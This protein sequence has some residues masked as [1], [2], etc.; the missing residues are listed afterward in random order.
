MKRAL[1]DAIVAL[2]YLKTDAARGVWKYFR[3]TPQCNETA[4]ARRADISIESHRDSNGSPQPSPP[5]RYRS[6]F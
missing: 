5:G 4:Q 2:T 6:R 1:L 3:G